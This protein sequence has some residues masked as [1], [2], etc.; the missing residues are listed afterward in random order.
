MSNIDLANSCT[1][2]S[3]VIVESG[4]ALRKQ[5]LLQNTIPRQFAQLHEQ[6]LMHIHDLEFYDVCYNCLGVSIKDM[7]PDQSIGI[8]QVLRRLF[9]KIVDLTNLQS[10][11]IGFINFDG[12][13]A[14]YWHQEKE[15]DM[16]SYFREFFLD[17]N[18]CTRKG[19]EKPYVT[20]NFGLDTSKAGRTISR[21]LLDAYLLGDN[22]HHP[23]LFP[24][25]VFKLKSGYNYHSADPNY[26]LFQKAVTVTAQR[27]VPTYF[28]CDSQYNVTF[29]PNIIGIM[30]CRTRVAQN[31]N[32]REGALNRGNIA[33]VTLNLVQ[34]AWQAKHSREQFETILR[35]LMMESK[36]LL[37]HRFYTLCTKA[38]L[39]QHY[40]RGYYLDSESASAEKMFKNG[41]LSIGFIGLWDA[42]SVL[43]GKVFVCEEDLKKEL[44]YGLHIVKLMRNSVDEYMQQTGMNFSLLA[45]AAEGVTGRFASYDFQQFNGQILPSTKGFYSNSFHV[46]VEMEMDCFTKID[47]EKQ[48]HPLCN[49]GSITYVE[50]AEI[51]AANTEAVE[52]IIRYAH[53]A[54]C[55][56][57]GINFPLDVCGQCGYSGRLGDT[58]PNCDS[59]E[60]QR[61]RR[62]SGYLSLDKSFTEGKKRELAARKSHFNR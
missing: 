2:A 12:D 5:E 4:A 57:F 17:L 43:S 58:C 3:S 18:V 26:D 11:G 1:N 54:E 16:V 6:R 41:T 28:N 47:L 19:D 7:V 21:A 25:L 20:L 55:N 29:S 46:P 53:D 38:D 60:I 59:T 8:A 34:I 13:L 50:F 35:Q 39:S 61:L 62:V 40:L 31:C 24:N 49:G 32:G 15:E 44:D 33:C 45:S 51:P 10:G 56:Y 23:F 30:G 52:E 14:G 27:M 36:K 48:F 37:L 42:L 9:R 22:D